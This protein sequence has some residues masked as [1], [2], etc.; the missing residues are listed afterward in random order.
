[1]SG[2]REE[3]KGAHTNP[4]ALRKEDLSGPFGQRGSLMVR[5]YALLVHGVGREDVVEV[6]TPWGVR[7][8]G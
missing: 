2:C 1:M 4:G 5:A 8:L 6:S 3:A 7:A